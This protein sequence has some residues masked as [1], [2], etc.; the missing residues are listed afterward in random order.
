MLL[1][2]I[3]FV[4]KNVPAITEGEIKIVIDNSRLFKDLN[5]D[6]KNSK[7]RNDAEVSIKIF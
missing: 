4:N 1:D 6:W 5:K 2:L 7:Y 3:E